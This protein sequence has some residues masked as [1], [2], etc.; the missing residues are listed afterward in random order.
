MGCSGPTDPGKETGPVI[1]A[2]LA[3]YHQTALVYSK[4]Y[5]D[6]EWIFTDDGFEINSATKMF[7]AYDNSAGSI[8]F[9]GTIV[10]VL[11]DDETDGRLIIKITDGGTWYK[12][13]G[14]YYAV[15]YKNLTADSVEE[16]GA[17]NGS[18]SYNGGMDT[19]A[20]AAEEYT[21]DNSYF[22]YY[23][24]YYRHNVTAT[25]LS[26]LQGNWAY[27]DMDMYTVIK[28]TTF[29]CFIDGTNQYDGVYAPDDD[30]EDV[31]AA[32]GDIVEHTSSSTASGI[33]Y[34]KTVVAGDVGMY[35][36]DKYVAVAW[37]NKA[38]NDIEFAMGSNEKD[39]LAEIKTTYGTLADFP[40]NSF[41]EYTKQ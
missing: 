24:N 8:S 33:F 31:L 14:S 38:D 21:V 20:E 13:A 25:T 9:A 26:G 2:Y 30:N 32:A 23:G 15:A 6:N 12:S 27:S 18:S 29:L 41:F 22:V 35:P 19:L 10:E 11:A 4:G 40:V 36:N 39:S 34:V 37:Q 17:F 16:S 3:G 7:Y 28:G 1:P 5:A